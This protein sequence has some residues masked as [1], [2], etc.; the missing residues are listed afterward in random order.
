MSTKLSVSSEL[1]SVLLKYL[2]FCLLCEI[3]V[4]TVRSTLLT[5]QFLVKWM[6]DYFIPTTVSL[7]LVMCG[8]LLYSLWC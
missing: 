7:L 5:K 3:S 1:F 8:D 6:R 2:A 4:L